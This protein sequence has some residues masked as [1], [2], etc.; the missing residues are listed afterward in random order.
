MM[1]ALASECDKDEKMNYEYYNEIEYQDYKINIVEMRLTD[2]KG[3]VRDLM[4]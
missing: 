4:I 2:G 3:K 1:V